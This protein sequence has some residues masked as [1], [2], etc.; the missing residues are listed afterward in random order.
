VLSSLFIVD[1]LEPGG[2]GLECG[3]YL[4]VRAA[5]HAVSGGAELSGR[6]DVLGPAGRGEGLR[7]SHDDAAGVKPDAS[8][9]DRTTVNTG[10]VRSRSPPGDR[11]VAG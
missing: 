2:C 5:R 1:Q 7:R 3:A 8:P 9:V 11:R 10:T 4:P 6:W